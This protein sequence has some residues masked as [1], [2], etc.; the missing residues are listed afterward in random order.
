MARFIETIRDPRLVRNPF[1]PSARR[2]CTAITISSS[3]LLS[4]RSEKSLVSRGETSWTQRT[5]G[6][7]NEVVRVVIVDGGH[8]DGV[9]KRVELGIGEGD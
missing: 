1:S 2:I 6:L 3:F 4:A 7:P 5:D 8:C 9:M